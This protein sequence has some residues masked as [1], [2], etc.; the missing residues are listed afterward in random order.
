MSSPLGYLLLLV[1]YRYSGLIKTI[2]GV[3]NKAMIA[4]YALLLGKRITDRWSI[5]FIEL[6]AILAIMHHTGEK[7]GDLKDL[8]NNLMKYF[9]PD[10]STGTNTGRFF[11]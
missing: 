1:I 10:A 11:N 8:K 7:N 2:I 6:V 3:D 5:P 4:L 9:N